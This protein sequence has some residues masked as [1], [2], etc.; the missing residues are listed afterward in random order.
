MDSV[1]QNDVNREITECNFL[2]N[3]VDEITNQ[4]VDVSSDRSAS[5]IS[6][7]VKQILSKYAIIEREANYA[8]L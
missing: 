7:A 8:G 5:T 4:F 1:I 6:C 3:Q 2:S